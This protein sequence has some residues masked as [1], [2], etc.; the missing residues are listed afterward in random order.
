MPRVD[1]VKVP[2]H[3][4]K[5]Q[6]ARWAAAYAPRIALI[7]VGEGN[8][9]GHPAPDTLAE[10][11]AVGA[12]VGRTDLDGDLAVVVGEDGAPQLLRRGRGLLG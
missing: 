6:S 7:G 4:S 10:Y 8:D 3:G 12:V 1:V 11:A 5:H 9:Y 2:H